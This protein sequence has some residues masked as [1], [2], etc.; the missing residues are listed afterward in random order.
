MKV[1]SIS[2]YISELILKLALGLKPGNLVAFPM[3]T[4]YGLG[5]DA[6]NHRAVS[7]IY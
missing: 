4:V 5:A 6:T 3:E 7:R 1:V 2:K